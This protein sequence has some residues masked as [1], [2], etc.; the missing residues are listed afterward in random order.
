MV[1][2]LANKNT[3]R[4]RRA[5]E[6]N[7]LVWG[8]KMRLGFG[9]RWW[10]WWRQGWSWSRK[11][12]GRCIHPHACFLH[13]LQPLKTQTSPVSSHVFVRPWISISCPSQSDAGSGSFRSFRSF[14]SCFRK[15][16]PRKSVHARLLV[17][18]QYSLG[19]PPA[20]WWYQEGEFLKS[21]LSH[22]FLMTFKPLC[23]FRFRLAPKCSKDRSFWQ[24]AQ[25]EPSSRLAM[26]T[27]M[28][29]SGMS[30]DKKLI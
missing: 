24:I 15:R 6:Q 11:F 1:R 19:R 4:C 16:S 30:T 10:R 25:Q 13:F 27:W 17:E 23:L 8:I 28:G 3:K 26:T 21:N 12:S 29:L 2:R 22:P 14:L 5:A 7:G 20:I 18:P 9:W